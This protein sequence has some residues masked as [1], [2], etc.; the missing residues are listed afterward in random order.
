MALDPGPRLAAAGA[1][2]LLLAT[3][4]GSISRNDEPATQ[5]AGPVGA[6]EGA[7]NVL[8]WPGYLTRAEDSGDGDPAWVSD[9][10]ADTGCSVNVREF[11]TSDE[12]VSLMS[13]GSWDVVTAS[14]DASTRLIDEGA[15]QP[16]NTSLIS[17]YEDIFAGLK[18][19]TSNTVDGAVYG[20][21]LGRSANLLMYNSKQVDPAPK[22]WSAT[23][24]ADSK[25]AGKVS[26]YD[27]PISIADAAVYLMGKQPDLAITDPYSLDQVQFD[28]A[29]ALAAQQ[30]SMSSERWS[31]YLT[32]ASSFVLG[33][34]VIGM[35]WN[36]TAKVAAEDVPVKTAKPR[37][38]ATGRADSWMISAQGNNINCSYM[39]IDWMLSPEVNAAAA[40]HVG[41]APANEQAC[42]QTDDEDY[43]EKSHA[44]DEDY[45]QDVYL[46]RT[47]SA[48]CL[49]GR[50]EVECVPYSK[51]VE[52][53]N[54][55][56]ETA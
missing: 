14:G 12:A 40:E 4:C 30:S 31:D 22:S 5:Y 1:V 6:G 26:V 11:G 2:V 56:R 41:A 38:G 7:V 13:A 36:V 45:W 46:W 8:A 3:G 16:I 9:F 47:P 33:S 10:E 17:A 49:D 21:P 44:D 37:E 32:Q 18:D 51:W 15:V 54:G 43:C 27:N 39:W 19:R 34:S 53:W 25:Q 24:E 20:V 29:V 52:A 48:Q 35:G 55:L 50:T 28:A 23:F 42:K